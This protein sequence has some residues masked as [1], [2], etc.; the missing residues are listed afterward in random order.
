MKMTSKVFVPTVSYVWMIICR[1]NPHF[2]NIFPNKK[3][4]MAWCDFYNNHPLYTRDGKKYMVF[5]T[6]ISDKMPPVE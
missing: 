3:S 1:G 5:K 6:Q 2:H 4:A